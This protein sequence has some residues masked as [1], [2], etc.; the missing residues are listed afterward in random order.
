MTDLGTGRPGPYGSVT[1][2][3]L[4]RVSR[5]YREAVAAGLSDA[6][7]GGLP[8]PAYWLLMALASGATDA[9]R[10][11]GAMGV[12]KQAVSKVVDALVAEGFVRRKP[13]PGDRRR[14]DLVLTAKGDRA[15]GV[16]RSAVRTADRSCRAEV[17][18]AAWET[19]VAT[20]ATLAGGED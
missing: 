12:S 16:I 7:L 8:R 18:A 13:N 6:R 9:S 10:L 4:R 14:T 11:V 15:A 3:L 1:P 20:L 5:R 17:G 2:W 19:T